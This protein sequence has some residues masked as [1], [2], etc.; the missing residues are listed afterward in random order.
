M[1]FMQ[2]KLEK[3]NK[4]GTKSSSVEWKLK[5][6]Q[7]LIKLNK[8]LHVWFQ[9]SELLMLLLCKGNSH[10]FF[11]ACHTWCPCIIEKCKVL[12]FCNER[13]Q[14]QLHNSIKVAFSE[15]SLSKCQK[16][17]RVRNSLDSEVGIYLVNKS[18]RVWISYDPGWN[19]TLGSF[20][21]YI[22]VWSLS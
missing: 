1:G 21:R 2:V 9:T 7:E 14:N 22:L 15:D 13:S 18:L 5:I 3:L 16:Y 20:Q 6:Y 8:A 17:S 11:S 4:R 12:I 10:L 19:F